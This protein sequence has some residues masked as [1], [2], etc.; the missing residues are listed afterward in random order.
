M[1]LT[2]TQKLVASFALAGIVPAV[3]VG[4]VTFKATDRM[5]E[6]VKGQY[7]QTAV[8]MLD[9]VERNLFERYG[10]VQAFGMNE[11]VNRQDEW[12]H[13]AQRETG[14]VSVMNNYVSCYGIYDVT[15]LVDLKGKV[16]AVNS[17][18]AAG[19][20]VNTA[21]FYNENFA[22]TSWFKDALA[23]NFLKSNILTGTVVEDAYV[24]PMVK[25]AVGGDGMVLG[26]SAPVRNAA[27]ETIGVWKNFAKWSLVKDIAADTYTGLRTR[28]QPEAE[29]TILKRDGTMLLATEPGKDG[30]TF[31]DDE[32]ESP[33]KTNFFADASWAPIKAAA[34]GEAGAAVVVDERHHHNEIVGYAQSK[35]ALGYPG[36]GWVALVRMDEDVAYAQ[37]SSIRSQVM[38]TIGL[39]S[40]LVLGGAFLLARSIGKPIARIAE[41]LTV[42]ADQTAAASGQ[43]SGSS[44]SLAQGATEQ[45]ASLST[46]VNSAEEMA[47]LTQQSAD[48]A[49]Q[50][51]SLADQTRNFAT[52]GNSAMKRMNTA[53]QDIE[54]SANETAQILKTIDEIAF[55]TNL[56]ALNAA[57]EAA[58]AG[59]A[60]K[61]FA[62]VAEEVRNLAMRS[63]ESAR[64][65]ATL[66]EQSVGAA[67]NGVTITRDVEASLLQITEAADKVSAII[68]EIAQSLAQ[69]AQGIDRINQSVTQMDKVTQQNAANAEESAAASEQ[70]SAQ[71]EQLRLCVVD[72]KHV[73]GTAAPLKRAA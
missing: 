24:D 15:L 9:V 49:R 25:Q 31:I 17:K 55:Q 11:I 5:A 53:I 30:A 36:L 22:D 69:Q 6:D 43:V 16:I 18:N 2:L 29:L 54:R 35:G 12:Y 42:G 64:N 32:N 3:V 56:L 34:T 37:M 70:L 47:K 38:L 48:S 58:R 57:V 26:F 44:Q 33:L 71:A 41:Q 62:V 8:A 59:E 13:G 50:A 14:V 61:G 51:M 4:L 40:T 23:G 72:L 67:R 45:A 28:G 60:G 68:T 21:A 63:A 46:T 19:Q 66:A 27:G 73:I 65:T 20:P 7:T 52:S 39:F 1:P 10:D